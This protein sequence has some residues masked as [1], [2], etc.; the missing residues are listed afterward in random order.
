MEDSPH[1][2]VGETDRT[3]TRRWFASCLAAMLFL[4][5]AEISAHPMTIK[6]VVVAVDKTRVQVA[7]LDDKDDKPGKPEWHVIGPKVKILRGDKRV[8]FANA[9]ITVNERI[10]L[11]V[12]HGADS[13]MTVTEVRLAAK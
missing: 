8:T 10:A 3:M 7:P 1:A 2:H 9:K 13:K 6:G 4:G 11:M 12:D 5:V